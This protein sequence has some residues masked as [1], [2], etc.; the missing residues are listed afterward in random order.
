M[1][2]TEFTLPILR[3]LHVIA[4]CSLFGTLMSGAV[5]IPM[6]A[7]VSAAAS[8]HA[9][10]LRLVRCNLLIAACSGLLWF[11]AAAAGIA[12][13]LT[14]SQVLAAIPEVAL[15]THFGHMVLARS[16]L[17]L[18]LVPLAV[19]P[20]PRGPASFA[21]T[22]LAG[23][24]LALQAATSHASAMEGGTGAGLV[25]AEALHLLAAGA[26]LGGLLPLL[27]CVRF[28][29]PELAAAALRR[30][31]PLGCAAVA[32]LVLTSVVSALALVGS[33]PALIGT[34]YGRV[35]LL[36]LGLFATLFGFAALNRLV[37]C[38]RPG[39]PLRRSLMGE[40]GV[41]VMLLIAAGSLA[42]LTPGAHEQ[43]EWPFPWRLEPGATGHLIPAYPTSFYTLP[44]PATA[45]SIVRGAR[46]YEAACASCHGTG[47]R[48]DGP[49]ASTLP[50]PPPDLTA[51]RVMDYADGDLFWLAGHQASA[52]DE[53]R[54]DLVNFLRARNRGSIA[55][56]SGKR[57]NPSRLP[58][59]RALC[60]D[61]S[62][63]TPQDL[64]GR[65]LRIRVAVAE[66]RPAL[67]VTRL[68]GRGDS[69]AAT[70]CIGQ[71]EALES[72]GIIL[73]APPGE[74]AGSEFLVDSNGW[75]RALWR[76][77]DRGGWD[78]PALLLARLQIL[79]DHPLPLGAG[80]PHM[81]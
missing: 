49:A 48:G 2:G 15:Y 28:A 33:V 36:K 5:V 56:M 67:D 77:G 64:E 58:L 63:I 17:L 72:L 40:T 3:G 76:R 24:T 6:P 31:F 8:L 27:L 44:G 34:S 41:A 42:H 74:L 81:H 4:L 29:P 39:A 11:T 54:W 73:G 12:G 14:A 66:R 38:T 57:F 16:V 61:G 35:A 53:V 46:N 78:T 70:E 32:T 59:F 26:W 1:T 68:D 79:A 25:A 55:R 51:H 37:F 30:F 43:P 65:A 47:G 21:A 22:M 7:S 69:L 80:Q 45:D 71:S 19:L 60:T 52:T 20:A 23:A 13:A 10:L 9:R 62:V 50:T 75:L 18:L